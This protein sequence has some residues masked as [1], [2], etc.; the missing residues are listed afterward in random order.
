LSF[1]PDSTGLEE[2]PLAGE[3]SVAFSLF[4]V[5]S[6][7]EQQSVGLLRLLISLLSAAI[8][9]DSERNTVLDPL[10]SRLLARNISSTVCGIFSSY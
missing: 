4:E 3:I 2:V 5:I 9:S 6:T 8:S 10:C 7:N 1:L